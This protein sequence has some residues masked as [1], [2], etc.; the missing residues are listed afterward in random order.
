MSGSV[1][2]LGLDNVIA[3]ISSKNIVKLS[4]KGGKAS[5]KP[6]FEETV[7][8]EYTQDDLLEDLRNAF[9]YTPSNNFKKYFLIADIKD[10]NN[11]PRVLNI[12]FALNQQGGVSHYASKEEKI[13]GS[14]D[15]NILDKYYNMGKLE[16]DNEHLRKELESYNAE[17]GEED[18]GA[19]P[20]SQQIVNVL[21]PMAP[22]IIAGVMNWMNNNNNQPVAVAGV[23]SDLNQLMNEMIAIEP[24]FPEHLSMLINLRKEKPAI[25]TMALNQLK[26]L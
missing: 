6:M 5:D 9:R 1:D 3:Y 20:I 26:N 8:G 24:E 13:A 15:T 22:Q 14:I 7:I 2:I 17:D 4:V 16:S 10:K 23:P 18:I 19:V 12:E 25:Y 21:L 11:K